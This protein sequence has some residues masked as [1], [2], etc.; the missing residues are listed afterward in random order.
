MNTPADGNASDRSDDPFGGRGADQWPGY[1][2]GYGDPQYGSPQYG[3][4][5]Y[6]DPQYGNPQY[7]GPFDPG[8][9]GAQPFYGAAQ[10]YGGQQPF[11]MQPHNPQYGAMQ[12][13]GQFP[14]AARKDPALMLVASLLVPG[15]GT[16]LN[17]QVGKGIGILGGY[18]VGLVL[19]VVLIGLPIMFGFWIWGMIDAYRGAKDHNARH[20]LP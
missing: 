6:G 2:S 19:S 17:G 16:M 10:A 4:P 5:Q 1:G 14:P 15:L 20:G 9:Y 18:F 12:P 8:H 13:Y 11:G 3:N 7:G